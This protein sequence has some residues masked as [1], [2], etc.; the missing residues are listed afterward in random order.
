MKYLPAG[1]GDDEQAVQLHQ[2]APVRRSGVTDAATKCRVR[3]SEH[4][5]I[6][7]VTAKRT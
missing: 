3:S 2:R 6:K 7:C 5:Y 4:M 1:R